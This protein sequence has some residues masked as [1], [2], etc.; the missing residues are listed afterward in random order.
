MKYE[1]RR[2]ELIQ[3]LKGTG[4]QYVTISINHVAEVLGIER[5]EE[6]HSPGTL[7]HVD[8]AVRFKRA[9]DGSQTVSKTLQGGLAEFEREPLLEALEASPETPPIESKPPQKS[10]KTPAARVPSQVKQE[11]PKTNIES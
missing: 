10:E 3:G 1:Q 8:Q 7:V 11:Q 4:N 5:A 2:K 6:L 9:G